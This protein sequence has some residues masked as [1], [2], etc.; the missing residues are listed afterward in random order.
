MMKNGGAHYP[1]PL[2]VGDTFCS[3]LLALMDMHNASS[4]DF[5]GQV[6]NGG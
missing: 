5:G 4:Y 1:R 6:S 3:H 2:R